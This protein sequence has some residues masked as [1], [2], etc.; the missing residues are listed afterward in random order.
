[1]FEGYKRNFHAEQGLKDLKEKVDTLIV[2]PNQRLLS[3]VEKQT[4][5][6]DAFNIADEVLRHAV[7][8]ISDLI[9]IP[10]LI[11]LDFADVKTIMAEMGG[12][13]MGTGFASGDNKAVKAAEMAITSPLLDG[14]SIDGARGVLINV[15]GGPDLTLFEINEATSVIYERAH[16]E[17][18]IIFGAVINENLQNE[19]RVTVIATG[20]SEAV[21]AKEIGGKKPLENAEAKSEPVVAFPKVTEYDESDWDIPTFVRRK[22]V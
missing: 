18:N 8:G 4:S 14:V 19:I 1:V 13:L 12:A 10:G 17:A 16:K 7:Q 2:I 20:F 11:N 3:V 15:T 6:I 5:L 21:V 9:T 22:A